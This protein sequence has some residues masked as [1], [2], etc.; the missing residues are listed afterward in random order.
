MSISVKCDYCG[1]V[2]EVEPNEN[3]RSLAIHVMD[4]RNKFQGSTVLFMWHQRYGDH[5]PEQ[6]FPD[7]EGYDVEAHYARLRE[8]RRQLHGDRVP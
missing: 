2:R 1:E 8:L 5:A 3:D 4:H 7:L 6:V